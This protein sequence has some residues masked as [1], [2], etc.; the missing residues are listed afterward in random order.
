MGYSSPARCHGSAYTKTVTKLYDAD[1]NVTSVWIVDGGVGCVRHQRGGQHGDERH[2][3]R[4]DGGATAAVSGPGG[5]HREDH[6]V[7]RDCAR[8]DVSEW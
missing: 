7:R 4:D 6:S 8:W 2:H 3:Q 5:R 1:G